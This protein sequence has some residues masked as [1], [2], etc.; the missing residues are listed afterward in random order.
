[1]QIN[2]NHKEGPFRIHTRNDPHS[3]KTIKRIQSTSFMIEKK[4]FKRGMKQ[5]NRFV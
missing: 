5:I 2:Q 1:M 3:Q 4:Q